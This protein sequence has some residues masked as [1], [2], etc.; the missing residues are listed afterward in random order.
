MLFG[1]VVVVGQDF[2]LQCLSMNVFPKHVFPPFCSCFW[3]LLLELWVPH[4]HV[5]VQDSH[6]PHC[7]H[8]QSTER[9]KHAFLRLIYLDPEFPIHTNYLLIAYVTSSKSQFV[10]HT[11]ARTCVALPIFG[12]VSRAASSTV[13][14]MIL[15]P[16]SWNLSSPS[17]C[18]CARIPSV[19]LSPLTVH[20]KRKT[21]FLALF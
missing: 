8:W 9:G 12:C 5:F 1:L 17:T 4:P 19:P 21:L 15:N 7:P 13:L 16:P 6:L 14:L 20:W 2:L 18:L 3:I 10:S 11:W